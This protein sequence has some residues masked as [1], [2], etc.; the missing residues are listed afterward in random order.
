M[1]KAERA[2][3]AKRSPK[4][5][6]AVGAMRA[7]LTQIKQDVAGIDVGSEHHYV[8][9]PEGRDPEPVRKFGSFTADLYRMVRWLLDCGIQSVVMQAT[10]VYWF[11]LY[12]V[13]EDHGLAVTVTNA[14]YTKMLPGRK[15]DVAECQWLQQ[16]ESF[17]LLTQSFRPTEEI[18]VLR[19][20]KRQRENLV[21][22]IGTCIQRMQK[23][24]TE[25]NLQLCHVLSD[26]NG[27]SGMAIL[28]AIVQGERDAYQLADLCD[29]RI[30]ATRQQ[31]AESLDGTWR[32]ELLFIL[33]QQLD[34]YDA[35]TGQVSQC[36][37]QIEAHLQTIDEKIDAAVTPMPAPRR[38]NKPAKRKHIPQ[39]DLR[40]Y[41]Y[42]IAGVDLTQ[43][44]GIGEQT[45]LTVL[46]E[47]GV[48]M[49]K[50][51]TEKN[52][53]SWLGLSPT[54]EKT[55]G[56]VIKR[57]T[58]KVV[59]RAAT[60]L[61]LAALTLRTS[62]SFLGAKYRR[63]RGRMDA[64]KAITA[65]AHHLATLLYRLLKFGHNY[66]DKG[67]E[68]YEQRYRERQLQYLKKQAAIQGFQL[69]PLQGVGA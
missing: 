13:L 42:Q 64:A 67:M 43:I 53:A 50:W 39:Y 18:R 25:M 9:V 48:D 34:L 36:D 63:L 26:L 6:K 51:K 49:S 2:R 3:Q 68:F 11:G 44:D 20:Y 28:R 22:D 14:R 37:Q 27:K 16:L 60:A 24:L 56:K 35:Y 15:S 40:R 8:A 52:F 57:G 30:Q 17:G 12:Q 23:A 41:L 32:N 1:A 46:S 69:A 19:T 38:P 33:Q 45:A 47:V 62:K 31:V 29:S 5:G 55:G 65:M 66:T 58:K 21:A 54:N 10:G 4:G 61:R 59:N 7:G